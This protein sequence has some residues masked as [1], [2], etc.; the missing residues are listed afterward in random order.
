MNDT[1]LVPCRLYDVNVDD[2]LDKKSLT[3][4]SSDDSLSSD[5]L[6]SNLYDG[7]QRLNKVREEILWGTKQQQQTNDI[8]EASSEFQINYHMQHL[9]LLLNQ[10]ADVANCITTKYQSETD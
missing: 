1:V 7:F 9:Q 8:V 3:S 2:E 5:T 10:F 4:L 6:N